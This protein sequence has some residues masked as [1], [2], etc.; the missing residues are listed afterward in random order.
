MYINS[1]L[2]TPKLRY[3]EAGTDPVRMPPENR[4]QCR[5]IA[6][7]NYIYNCYSFF[8]TATIT[9]NTDVATNRNLQF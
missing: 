7:L 1:L 2:V 9:T 3:Q 6:V 8:T 5:C 4:L